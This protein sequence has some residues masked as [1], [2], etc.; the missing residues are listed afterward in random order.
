MKA[1]ARGAISLCAWFALLATGCERR[2]EVVSCTVSNLA[3]CHEWLGRTP[4]EQQQI[5]VGVCRSGDER[6][7]V[8][9]CPRTELLGICEIGATRE[10]TLWY[11]GRT[12]ST[13]DPAAECRRAS[14]EWRPSP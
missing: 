4:A 9:A 8:S 1:P 6:Y 7:E 12:S 3:M 10:R 2:A 11:R 13:F 5:R 14:G